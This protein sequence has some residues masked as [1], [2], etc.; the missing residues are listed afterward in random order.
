M[1]IKIVMIL[2]SMALSMDAL[3]IGGRAEGADRFV[4]NS[5]G[6]ITDTQ[7]GLMWANKDNGANIA[8]VD[9]KGYCRDYRG[10]GHTDWRMPTQAELAGLY[11]ATKSRP[12]ECNQRFPVHVATDIINITCFAMWA[13]ETKDS[14]GTIFDFYDGLRYWTL[15]SNAYSNRVLPVRTGKK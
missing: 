6:T 2:L 15:Q 14:S 9:A 8:W 3:A 10:G 1:A 11:D 13:L 7:T 12:G 4:S 5:D